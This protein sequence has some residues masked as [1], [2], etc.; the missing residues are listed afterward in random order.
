MVVQ[1]TDQKCN[2]SP[3][4]PTLHCRHPSHLFL[5][6]INLS[7]V[8]ELLLQQ[9]LSHKIPI[10]NIF[11]YI[12]QLCL[13]KYSAV[14]SSRQFAASLLLKPLEHQSLLCTLARSQPRSLRLVAQL[15]PLRLSDELHSSSVYLPALHVQY[16]RLPK[17]Q[18]AAEL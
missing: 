7:F 16:Q 6:L 13:Q 18:S 2:T 14:Q 8:L 5:A 12:S 11:S 9:L 3:S 17:H 10:S 15:A 4:L 1:Q